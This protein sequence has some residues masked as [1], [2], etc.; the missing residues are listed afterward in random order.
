MYGGY[1]YCA[2]YPVEQLA[3]DSKILSLYEGTN[4]IQ[5]M[6]LAMRKLLMNPDMYNYSIFKKRIGETMERA[7]GVVDSR[8]CLRRGKGAGE[9][10]RGGRLLAKF[11]DAG[12]H[13][14]DLCASRRRSS[15][16]SGCSPTR[17]CTSGPFPSAC[18]QLKEIAGDAVGRPAA[19]PAPGRIPRAAYYYGKMLSV[20]VLSR[21]GVQE[22]FRLPGFYRVGRRRCRGIVRG[23]FYRGA[24]GVTA[25]PTFPS[26]RGGW[27][28]NMISFR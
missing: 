23:D 7:R 4:G 1:G 20:Q 5:S 16:P 12:E 17:G 28:I 19:G 8:L 21:H 11:R 10:G 27:G 26:P 14:A 25:P 3:R 2:D 6:D 13:G 9:D 22:I 24:G 18:P 15:R